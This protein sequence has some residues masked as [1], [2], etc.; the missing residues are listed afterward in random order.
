MIDWG[1][2]PNSTAAWRA[3]DLFDAA[4]MP[5]PISARWIIEQAPP[6]VVLAVLHIGV[7]TCFASDCP[8][9][10]KWL[11][12]FGRRNRFARQRTH[13]FASVGDRAELA[14]AH[15]AF[16]EVLKQV[17][18]GLLNPSM[19]HRLLALRRVAFDSRPFTSNEALSMVPIS[20]RQLDYWASKGWV[21]PSIDAG[22][23]RSGTRLWCLDDVIRLAALKY[24][25]A[26]GLPVAK[27][28]E[29]MALLE[30]GTSRFVVADGRS[31]IA[32]CDWPELLIIIRQPG[33]FAVFD[34]LPL[35][36]HAAIDG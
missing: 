10:P 17:G 3:A 30:V 1:E 5:Q 19:R 25:T 32:T 33:K 24:I 8:E 13:E 21:V 2:L 23:G 11:D 4:E 29:Q 15:G 22:S 7:A 12:R 18:P 34:S 31:P 14:A 6:L 35:R 9:G 27:T 28:G 36:E 20:Y 16:D 26:C